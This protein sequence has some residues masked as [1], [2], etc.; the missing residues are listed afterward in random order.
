MDKAGFI[1]PSDQ[2]VQVK[3]VNLSYKT[4]VG[5]ELLSRLAHFDYKKP[6]QV[7]CRPRAW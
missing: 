4:Q 6:G 1:I 7:I 5:T 2:S 3:N